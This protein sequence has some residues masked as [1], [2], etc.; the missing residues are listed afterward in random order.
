MDLKEI[1]GSLIIKLIEE[2]VTLV[3]DDDGDVTGKKSSSLS[4]VKTS[5]LLNS[6]IQHCNYC[7][8]RF[9]I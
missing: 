1:I 8:N 7:I 6:I 5:I 9:V 2:N 4:L 3:K